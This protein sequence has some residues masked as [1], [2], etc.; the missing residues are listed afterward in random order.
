MLKQAEI[1]EVSSESSAD[2]TEMVVVVNVAPIKKPKINHQAKMDGVTTNTNV[3]SN[4]CKEKK[5]LAP[6]PMETSLVSK[7]K[8]NSASCTPKRPICP[9]RSLSVAI[10]DGEIMLLAKKN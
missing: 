5:L 6:F 9:H 4:F 3:L 1:I 2:S 8:L 7:R 10:G